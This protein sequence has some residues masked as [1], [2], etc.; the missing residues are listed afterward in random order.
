M[1][2]ARS[3][4]AGAR[5]PAQESY[6][7]PGCQGQRRFN[8]TFRY[9]SLFFFLTGIAF[10]QC[11]NIFLTKGQDIRLG[12]SNLLT[13]E[14]PEFVDLDLPTSFYPS[15]SLIATYFRPLFAPGDFGLAKM[16]TS[17]D[18]ASSVSSLAL[19]PIFKRFS[20]QSWEVY[21]WIYIYNINIY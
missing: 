15:S 18:L 21:I 3:A 4:P 12:Q 6:P 17:D 10:L 11:S 13:R 20:D 9:S 1:Q 19:L 16:L 7:A 14:R 5:L 2:V 8:W